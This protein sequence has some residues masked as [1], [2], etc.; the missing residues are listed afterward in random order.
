MNGSWNDSERQRTA[1]DTAGFFPAGL[2]PCSRAS[3]AWRIWRRVFDPLAGEGDGDFRG[4][5]LGGEHDDDALAEFGVRDA[6]TDA[7]GTGGGLRH[8]FVCLRPREGSTA[9]ETPTICRARERMRVRSRGLPDIS[10]WSRT[11]WSPT[12]SGCSPPGTSMRRGPAPGRTGRGG[13]R[14][15]SANRPGSGRACSPRSTRIAG[16]AGRG[17]ARGGAG[18]GSCRRRAGGAPRRPPC[19]RPRPGCGSAAAGR[20]PGRPGKHRGDRGLALCRV[21]RETFSPNA[22]ALSI[23]AERARSRGNRAGR[24]PRRGERRNG[25]RR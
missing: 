9:G 14:R 17:S 3:P 11:T 8:L 21:S 23:S 25:R 15:L 18:H 6:V 1:G 7:V 20:P 4:A 13:R 12:P 19:R 22:W 2:S 5:F 24:C 10:I 16:G